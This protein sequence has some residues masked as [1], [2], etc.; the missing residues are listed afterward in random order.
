VRALQRT[1]ARVCAKIRLAICVYGTLFGWPTSVSRREYATLSDSELPTLLR[2]TRLVIKRIREYV[3]RG[4]NDLKRRT[5][6]RNLYKC[7]RRI[8][9]DKTLITVSL[10]LCLWYIKTR[11][12]VH[13]YIYM[14]KSDDEVV[15]E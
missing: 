13:L 4:E 3:E 1:V 10:R 14:Y 8:V 11:D 5:H 6:R 7:L 15:F 12:R 9:F 2:R